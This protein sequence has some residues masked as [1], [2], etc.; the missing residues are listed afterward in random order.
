VV[1][2]AARWKLMVMGSGGWSEWWCVEVVN[3]GGRL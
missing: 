3:E 2:A 1:V